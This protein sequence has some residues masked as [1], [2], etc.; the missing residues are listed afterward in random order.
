MRQ[1]IVMISNP[2]ARGYSRNRIDAAISFLENNGFSAEL[3]LTRTRGHAE[4]MAKQAVQQRPYCIIAAGGD[5]TINEVMNG[6]INTETPLG[7]LPLGTS[8]V[9]ARE[10][11]V[12]SDPEKAMQRIVTTAPGTVS[13]GRLEATAPDSSPLDRHFILMAGIGFD[14]EAVLNADSGIK[15]ISGEGAYILSGIRS[16][17]R[18]SPGELAITADGRNF[19]GYAAIIGKAGRY[20]GDFRVTPDA[21]IHAPCFYACIFHGKGRYDLLRYAA[22]VVL[23]RHLELK[24]V[25][26]LKAS[27]ILVSGKAHIQIDGDYAGMTPARITISQDALRLI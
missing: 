7:I 1:K 18:Y 24:G 19:T 14:A 17:V 11:S 13:P 21:D 22:G 15:K 4:D 20:G 16:L 10:L 23:G 25:T 9:L 26:Y 5:G 12:S 6:M 27:E 8:N 3:L 2:A